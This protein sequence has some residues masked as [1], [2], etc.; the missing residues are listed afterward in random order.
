MSFISN[1]KTTKK[2]VPSVAAVPVRR[3][4]KTTRAGRGPI[5]SS[6]C[7][8]ESS[9]TLM[10]DRKRSTQN[11]TTTPCDHRKVDALAGW[12]MVMVCGV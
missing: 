7:K 11:Q 3:F 4:F 10:T 1:A 8:Q 6:G 9:L 12:R 2:D 5:T